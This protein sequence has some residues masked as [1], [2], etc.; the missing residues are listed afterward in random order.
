MSPT[1]FDKES[2]LFMAKMKKSGAIDKSIFSL[3]IAMGDL[4]SRITFGGYNLSAY[5]TSNSINWHKI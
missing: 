5:A 4:Q 3:S 2:D 1:H